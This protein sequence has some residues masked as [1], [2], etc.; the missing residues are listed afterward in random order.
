MTIH[1]KLN[2]LYSKSTSMLELNFYL[3]IGYQTKLFSNTYRYLKALVKALN[4][5]KTAEGNNHK[6][7]T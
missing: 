6:T 2:S 1:L 3:I 4:N 7:A 5:H